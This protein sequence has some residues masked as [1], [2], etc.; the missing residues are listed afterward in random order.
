MASAMVLIGGAV[1]CG[2]SF[3]MFQNAGPVWTVAACLVAA[4]GGTSFAYV[5]LTAARK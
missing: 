1:L 5:A 3:L 2:V 4:C